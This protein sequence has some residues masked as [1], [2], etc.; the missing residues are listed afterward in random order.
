MAA[1]IPH[2][3]HK[4][5]IENLFI[6]ERNLSGLV[7]IQ[8]P[9]MIQTVGIFLFH[10]GLYR[11][12]K[13]NIINVFGAHGSIVGYDHQS[14]RVHIQWQ[15]NLCNVFELRNHVTQR[16]RF[17]KS[18]FGTSIAYNVSTFQQQRNKSSQRHKF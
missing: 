8:G 11:F 3:W 7:T 4:P 6:F 5:E 2:S 12:G 15:R 17:V 1:C 9:D 10:F 13:T 16:A 14:Q 18:Y